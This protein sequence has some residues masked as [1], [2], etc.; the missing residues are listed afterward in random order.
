[1]KKIIF[2]ILFAAVSLVLSDSPS[3]AYNG[4]LKYFNDTYGTEG[5]RLNSCTLCHPG[6]NVS[7]INNFGSDYKSNG[8]FFDDQLEII[9]KL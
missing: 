4:E 5:T 3:F 7:S 8:W 2:I 6:S 1:M 9:P